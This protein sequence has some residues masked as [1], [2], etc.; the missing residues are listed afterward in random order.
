MEPRL[1]LP[2]I[3]HDGKPPTHFFREAI[4]HVTKSPGSRYIKQLL[5]VTAL[6]YTSVKIGHGDRDEVSLGITEWNLLRARLVN[7]KTV[8]LHLDVDYLFRL[9]VFDAEALAGLVVLPKLCSVQLELWMCRE[10]D[11]ADWKREI[12]PDMVIGLRNK[13]ASAMQARAKAMGKAV[14]ITLVLPNGHDEN[15]HCCGSTAKINA[16]A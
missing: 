15:C 8:R 13:I 5:L 11:S 12:T 10:I 1:C 16:N 9:E 14:A 7:I 2:D 6:S 3:G 4:A